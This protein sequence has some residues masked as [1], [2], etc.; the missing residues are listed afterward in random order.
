LL[1]EAK[2]KK[3]IVVAAIVAAVAIAATSCGSSP[4][5][6]DPV[7]QFIREARRNA[8]EDALLGIGRAKNANESLSHSA[9]EARARAEIARQ[10]EAVVTNMITDYNA[11]SEADPSAS[12]SFQENI[13]RT[14]AQQT[15]KGATI[16]DENYINGTTIVVVM[17]PKATLRNEIMGASQSAAALAPHMGSAQWALDRMDQALQ[18]Q[19]ALPPVISGD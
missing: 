13:T 9:A 10:V 18:Q 17:L 1:K 16:I 3:T 8:P 11:G 7:S 6:N 4:A 5:A 19:N 2:M 14:L 12:L 15:Q